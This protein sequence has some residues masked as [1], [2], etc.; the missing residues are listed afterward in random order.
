MWELSQYT[1]FYSIRCEMFRREKEMPKYIFLQL[2]TIKIQNASGDVFQML[3][4]KVNMYVVQWFEIFC[5][6][7]HSLSIVPIP[8]TWGI[9]ASFETYKS[10][11]LLVFRCNFK[12]NSGISIKLGNISA[13]LNNNG[14][15]TVLMGF[16]IINQY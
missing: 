13:S 8:L 7:H 4:H 11:K 12:T 14:I 1:L 2:R 9:R 6:K 10:R 16:K 15:Q 3:R 5:N